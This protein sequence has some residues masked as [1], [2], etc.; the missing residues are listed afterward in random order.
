MPPSHSVMRGNAPIT[1]TTPRTSPGR[2]ERRDE[3]G[4]GV[5][6]IS[7]LKGNSSNEPYE[8]K[9]LL[10][11]DHLGSSSDPIREQFV[12]QR[13]R[14]RQLLRQLTSQVTLSR[15]GLEFKL[16]LQDVV[17]ALSTDIVNTTGHLNHLPNHLSE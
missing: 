10:P 13:Y 2:R 14:G 1:P 17:F 6:F 16:N 8:L 4:R 11:D 7:E 5:A 15:S 3:L 9:P 12:D